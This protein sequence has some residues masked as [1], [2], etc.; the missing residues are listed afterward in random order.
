MNSL[1]FLCLAIF[2]IVFSIAS[3][4]AQIDAK[5]EGVEQSTEV[6]KRD[7]GERFEKRVERMAEKLNLTE[8]QKSEI[9]KMHSA[10]VREMESFKEEIKSKRHKVLEANDAKMKS[11]LTAEQYTEFQKMKENKDWQHQK[12]NKKGKNKAPKN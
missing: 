9:I 3:L 10:N 12:G 11:I 1:K 7:R 6:K 8:E 4:S 2:S 5:P